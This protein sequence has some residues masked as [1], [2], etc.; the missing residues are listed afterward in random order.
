MLTVRIFY[1]AAISFHR[2]PIFFAISPRDSFSSRRHAVTVIAPLCA[3]LQ[4]LILQLTVNP[5]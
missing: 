3:R 4:T 5:R 2:N 1:H